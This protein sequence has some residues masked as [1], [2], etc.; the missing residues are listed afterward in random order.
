MHNGAFAKLRDVVAFYATRSTDPSRWYPPHA[1]FDDLP[2]KYHDNVNVLSFPY[3][4]REGAPPAFGDE[5]IDAIV[6]FLGT[7]T[8][9]AYLPR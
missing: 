2:A 4:R 1:K 5:D 8:D 9:A 6:A 3:N 7:L